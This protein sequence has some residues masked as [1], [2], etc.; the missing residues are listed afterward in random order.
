MTHD[1]KVLEL[2]EVVFV[3]KIDEPGDDSADIWHSVSC[4]YVVQSGA[5]KTPIDCYHLSHNKAKH[6]ID[7]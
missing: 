3:K 4:R 2:Q 5:T 6:S 7:M 1:V